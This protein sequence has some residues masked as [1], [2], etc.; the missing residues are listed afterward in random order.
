MHDAIE[1]Y[2]H[3]IIHVELYSVDQSE[4]R[5]RSPYA[6]GAGAAALGDALRDAGGSGSGSVTVTRLTLR[7]NGIAGA[8]AGALGGAA[9]GRHYW[10]RSVL[11]P[12][13]HVA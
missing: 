2:R 12:H 11:S 7:C 1:L 6:Q 9:H 5:L 3:T 8:G 10:R 4:R 13:H